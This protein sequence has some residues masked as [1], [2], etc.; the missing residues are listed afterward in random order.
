M[1]RPSVWKV[2]LFGLFAV[3]TTIKLILEL[4]WHSYNGTVLWVVVNI[5]A[6]IVW[7]IAFIIT[8][9]RYLSLSE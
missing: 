9:T 1:K 2:V 8:L 5:I 6:P 4:K 3:T 7:T